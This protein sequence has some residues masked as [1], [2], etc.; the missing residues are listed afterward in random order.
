MEDRHLGYQRMQFLMTRNAH[1]FAAFL[2]RHP[3]IL[4][5]GEP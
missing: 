5:H 4:D 1:E 2:K 3:N